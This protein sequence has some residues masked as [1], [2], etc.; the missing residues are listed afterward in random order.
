[1]MKLNGKRVVLWILAAVLCVTAC[2]TAFA[3]AGDRV[4]YRAEMGEEGYAEDWVES[5][6]KTDDC[7]YVVIR[8][9]DEVILRY[10][11]LQG[12][13]EKF[14]MEY[15]SGE[16]PDPAGIA[17]VLSVDAPVEKQVVLGI[18][19]DDDEDEDED[20]EDDEDGG[21]LVTKEVAGESAAAEEPQAQV[22][23]GGYASTWFAWKG[24][25]YGLSDVTSFD[26]TTNRSTVEKIII[27]RAKMEDG[28]LSLEDSGLPELSPEYVVESWD[29]SEYFT[30]LNRAVVSGDY[31]AGVS[32]GNEGQKLVIFNLTDGSCRVLDIDP[33]TN[34]DLALNPDGTF[35]LARGK[36]A[37][38][39][40]TADIEFSVLNP[41]DLSETPLTQ[42]KE[43]KDS[44]LSACYDKEK[45]TLY[46]VNAGQLWAVPDLDQAKAEAVNECAES[47]PG[48]M[49]LPDGMMMIWSNRAVMIKNTDPSQRGGIT[50]RVYDTNYS[51]AINEAVFEMSNT[52]GDVSVILQ[53]DWSTEVDVLQSM[54]NRDGETDIFVLR[55]EGSD[56][57]ALRN[58]GFVTD[59]SGNAEIAASVERMYPWIRDAIQKD[60]K[61]IAIPLWFYAESINI[62]MA[63]WKELGGTEEELPKTWSQFF[64]WVETLP[65]RL[66]GKDTPLLENYIGQSSFRSMIAQAIINQYQE[67]MDS[68]GGDY[69]FNTPELSG[70]LKRLA[71]LNYDALG[72]PKEIDYEELNEQSETE[73]HE[74]LLNSYGYNG[75][76]SSPEYVPLMMTFGDEETPMF[77]V[78]IYAAFVNPYSEHKEEAM[79]LLAMTLK[80]EDVYSQYAYFADK[81]EPIERSDADEQRKNQDKYIEDIRKQLEKA[82]DANKAE[83]E[84]SLRSAE[85]DK[86]DMER[87][88]W[89][90]SQESL[91]R[92]QSLQSSFRVQ[93]YVLF[94]DLFGTED[95]KDR[96]KIFKG[97]FGYED[98]DGTGEKIGDVS[99]EDA[100]NLIDQKIQM[101]RKEGN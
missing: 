22:V 65:K 20:E 48:M 6:W 72:I 77:P 99:I 35:L 15:E 36:W 94:D 95:S 8:G 5:V 79:E 23:P 27:R 76:N 86:E 67:I 56:F 4:L 63:K 64:D 46:Y 40:N 54:M 52:R 89:T 39:Y 57:R 87:W 62:N 21:F 68:K 45:N 25:M 74:P 49:L 61:I 58:R 34:A 66:E 30:G 50:L 26:E 7:W 28:K 90:I 75:Y 19:D 33:N 71:G 97:L 14:V 9:R 18:G 96:E 81:T 29:N 53:Q 42:L 73:W 80:H 16:E 31:L 51:E 70:L 78:T 98:D 2:G 13:P 101:K 85:K 37:P 55:Y 84:E 93:G 10:R 38:D 41:D 17:A 1:M 11:D 59:L 44:Q 100:L 3:S 43:L 82:D 60:G 24:E 83:L 69:S 47:Y 92:Y 88:L 91:D 12:E 32:Y